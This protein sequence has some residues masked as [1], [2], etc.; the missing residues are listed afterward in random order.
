M[1]S[2]GFSELEEDGYKSFFWAD[3]WVQDEDEMV[4]GFSTVVTFLGESLTYRL[5]EYNRENSR[6][7]EIRHLIAET[8]ECKDCGSPG[9]A[10][11]MYNR[12]P[13]FVD[14][15]YPVVEYCVYC[16]ID[17]LNGRHTIPQL[18]PHPA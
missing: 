18:A 8:L 12:I 3:E 2:R 15:A 13:Y 14:V 10:E 5:P 7:F 9:C 17:E 4:A 11:Y 1:G 6:N 16:M